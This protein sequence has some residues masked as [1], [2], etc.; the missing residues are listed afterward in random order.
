M[1][2]L[3]EIVHETRVHYQGSA[4]ASYNEARMT[5]LTLPTQAALQTRVTVGNG[6]PVWAYQDYWGTRVSSFDIQ[7]PHEE[8]LV[9]SHSMVETMAAPPPPDPLSWA[10]LR[11]QADAGLAAEFLAATPRTT[12]DPA[13]SAAARDLVAG[14]DPVQT[15]SVIASWVRDRVAY[16]PGATEVQTGAQEAWDKGEGVCQDI[17]HLTV[18]LLREAGL[19]GPLR[20]RLPAPAA[21]SRHRHAGRRAEPRLGGVLGRQ[22]GGGRP[23]EPGPGRRVPRGGG[24]RPGLLRCAA[25]Q[26][27]LPRGAEHGHGGNGRGH[28]ARLTARGLAPGGRPAGLSAW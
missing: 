8:L 13:L 28:P 1:G 17:A 15:A 21:G 6:I 27:D 19:P 18:A 20:V 4:R 9:R 3:L 2:W 25:A 23:D 12:V 24:P 7:A 16:V 14:A 5:P 10:E 11:D 26:G 22:L